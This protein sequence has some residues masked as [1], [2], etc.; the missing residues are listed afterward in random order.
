MMF[1]NVESQFYH[2]SFCSDVLNPIVENGVKQEKFQFWS[3]YFWHVQFWIHSCMSRFDIYEHDWELV[4]IFLAL[5]V[6][7][8]FLNF[9]CVPIWAVHLSRSHYLIRQSHCIIFL[10]VFFLL[11]VSFVFIMENQAALSISLSNVINDGNSAALLFRFI[12]FSLQF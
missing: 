5:I 11:S 1:K 6:R 12:W 3:P 9:D 7:F 4:P 8:S 10:P 2:R